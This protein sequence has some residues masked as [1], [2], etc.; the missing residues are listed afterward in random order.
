MAKVVHEQQSLQPSTLRIVQS[1]DP[2]KV[3]EGEP[4]SRRYSR[5]QSPT[6]SASFRLEV[7]PKQPIA[8]S[9]NYNEYW[10]AARIGL[11]PKLG[12]FVFEGVIGENKHTTRFPFNENCITFL[13]SG[14]FQL[15]FQIIANGKPLVIST[16]QFKLRAALR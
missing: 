7:V 10:D 16:W 4:R 12:S 5:T 11:P 15:E 2:V 9:M 8:Y 3:G 6:M 1:T 13:P 14:I